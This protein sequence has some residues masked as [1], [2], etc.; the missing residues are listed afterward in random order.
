MTPVE[1][2]NTRDAG[3]S[4]DVATAS[5][6]ARTDSS[7]R[8]PVKALELPEL[9]MIAAP[10]F[11]S[12]GAAS[13]TSQSSTGAERVLERVVTPAMTLPGASCASITSVRFL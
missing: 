2:E 7:P 1:E 8:A 13:L 5:V 6:M 10:V 9:T 11:V 12:A 3:I 4:N